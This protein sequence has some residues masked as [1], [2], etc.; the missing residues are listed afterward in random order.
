MIFERQLTASLSWLLQKKHVNKPVKPAQKPI[1][2]HVTCVANV[3]KLACLLQMHKKM[4]IC[5]ELALYCKTKSLQKQS[6]Q[7]WFPQIAPRYLPAEK[8]N[9][10]FCRQIASLMNSC[11][12]CRA[13][14]DGR[15]KGL[16][17]MGNHKC[18]LN[19]LTVFHVATHP[20]D[21]P[22]LTSNAPIK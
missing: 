2:H 6:D 10:I 8:K 3:T 18:H 4:F 12:C 16:C 20:A 19:Y 7:R 1:R 17:C 5:G 14:T 22:S 11:L 13:L 9:C 21:V 15:N